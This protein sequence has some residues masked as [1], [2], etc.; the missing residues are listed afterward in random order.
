MAKTPAQIVE[1]ARKKN[2]AALAAGP[3]TAALD[4][5]MGGIATQE[6]PDAVTP[7]PELTLPVTGVTT[8]ED[9]P[10]FVPPIADYAADAQ[11]NAPTP[12]V[13]APAPEPAPVAREEEEPVRRNLDA[14]T[15][16]EIEAGRKALEKYK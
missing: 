7:E 10:A 15:K 13:T 1:E 14:G 6:A 11:I 9:A 3:D 8:I 2:A 12:I 5:L 4:E 16:A